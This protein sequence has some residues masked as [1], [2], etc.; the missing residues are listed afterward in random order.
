MVSHQASQQ[1][2]ETR[3]ERGDKQIDNQAEVEVTGVLTGRVRSQS[4]DQWHDIDIEADAGEMCTCE[5][6]FY[7]ENT[8]Q[9]LYAFA[10]EIGMFD[11]DT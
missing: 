5:D 6:H 9:H 11:L 8:C 3:I 10:D 7:R 1:E 2:F 4:R